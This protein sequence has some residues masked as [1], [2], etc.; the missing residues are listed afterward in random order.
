VAHHRYGSGKHTS[1][2]LPHTHTDNKRHATLPPPPHTTPKPRGPTRRQ[3][4]REQDTP[5]HTGVHP[6]RTPQA[7]TPQ[8]GSYTS[9][10]L[11]TWAKR[12]LNVDNTYKGRRQLQIIEC[13][14]STDGNI[15]KIIDHIHTIYEPL[16]NALQTYGTIQADIKIIPIVISRTCTFNVKTLAEIAELVTF[17]EE[18]PDA[19]TYKQLP[20]PAQTIVM[21]LHVHA[22]EW[23]SHISKISRKILTTKPK[24]NLT[25]TSP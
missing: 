4:H 20:K 5:H 25:P 11:H 16:K 15:T 10:R 14:Y 2:R 17:H 13:K 21:T 8:T 12:K 6:T 7:Q 19:L 23:L 18:P 22:Q 24:H 9:G 3:T 1:H